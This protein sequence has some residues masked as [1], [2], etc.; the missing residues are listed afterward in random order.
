M[1]VA[2]YLQLGSTPLAE[3]VEELDAAENTLEARD[4]KVQRR[5]MEV[6]MHS[7]HVESAL[8]ELRSNTDTLSGDGSASAIV[9]PRV[10]HW[11][12]IGIKFPESTPQNANHC[13]ACGG[14]NTI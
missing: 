2:G 7:A 13:V 5:A 8:N 9:V 10:E 11:S 6:V 3:D 1:D 12:S 14:I 4:I